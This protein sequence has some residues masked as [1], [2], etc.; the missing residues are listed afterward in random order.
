M[1][2]PRCRAG[3]EVI[4]L[5]HNILWPYFKNV[6]LSYRPEL[7]S[8]SLSRVGTDK[9]GT[10][11]DVATAVVGNMAEPGVFVR[12]AA[13][14]PR[15]GVKGGGPVGRW[16]DMRQNKLFGL[17]GGGAGRGICSYYSRRVTKKKEKKTPTGIHMLVCWEAGSL[18]CNS[19]CKN[20]CQN[21]KELWNKITDSL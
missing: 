9:A 8:P 21:Q 16:E 7:L 6:S 20:C 10:V 19:C 15:K 14:I 1:A 12:D 5:P 3:E 11:V 18:W 4:S 17:G 13:D 2:C